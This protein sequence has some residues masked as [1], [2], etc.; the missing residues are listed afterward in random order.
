LIDLTSLHTLSLSAQ[1]Q[2][3]IAVSSVAE[4]TSLDVNLD[5]FFILGGGSNVAFIDNFDGDVLSFVDKSLLIK[6]TGDYWQ[7]NAGAGLCWH[8]LVQTLINKGIG[9]LEN[10][11]LIPGSCGAAPVQN[12]GA[13]GAEFADFCH[14]VQVFDLRSKTI[15]WVNKAECEFAYRD[16]VFKKA[17]AQ[18][19]LVTQIEMR[20]PT[21]WQPRLNY[22]DLQELESDTLNPKLVMDKV[23]SIRESKLP[24]P[25]ELSNAGSFFKNPVVPTSVTQQ[26]QRQWPDIPV[27]QVNN[28]EDKLSAGWLIEKAGYKGKRVGNIG[29]YDRHALVVVNHGDGSG[30]ELH[31]FVKHIQRRVNQVFGVQLENEVL[32]IGKQG[33]VM[34]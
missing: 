26:L 18:F 16:S 33:P 23:I 28:E 21:Q 32:L 17:S 34:L 27:F 9:G 4:L 22:K 14:R 7:I 5:Y 1:C 31:A 24:N 6:K 15:K 25:A 20:L 8:A 11:A 13:Y 29:T 3:Y 30:P 2:R 10:L 12:I 19:W